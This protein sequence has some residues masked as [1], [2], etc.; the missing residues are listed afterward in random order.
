[1]FSAEED[2]PGHSNVAV[3]SYRLWMSH[4]N[5]DRAALDRTVEIDG[6][7]HTII[8]IMR[9]SFDVTRGSEDIWTPIAFTA[10]DATKYGEHYLKVFA[11]LRPGVTIAQARA[12]RTTVERAV[13]EQTPQRT[14]RIAD[15]GA[16]IHGYRDDLVGNY[17]SL[18]LV[19]LG[20]VGLVLLIA[21][22]NVAN[23]LLAR[24]TVRARELAIRAALGAG[25]GRLV[26][27]LLT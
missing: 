9:P 21:C 20:A 18:L 27:Q 4:F 10:D 15:F 17:R 25:R 3:I 2:S 8:G 6:T 24:A 19:L 26:R 23:L 16:D 11:R 13:A 22:V 1:T 7:P 5:G 14:L 12:A